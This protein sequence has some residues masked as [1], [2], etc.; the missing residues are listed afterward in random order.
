MTYAC[1]DY[2]DKGGR[3]ICRNSTRLPS[4]PMVDAL[5]CLIFAPKVAVR[6]DRRQQYFSQIICDDGET[7]IKLSHILTHQDVQI[8][9]KIR[10]MLNKSMCEDDE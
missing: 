5:F 7:I 8:A 9:Q 1:Q 10:E 3:F 4:L 6:A 2:Y